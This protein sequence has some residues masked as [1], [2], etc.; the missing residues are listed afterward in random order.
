MFI[1]LFYCTDWLCLIMY[2]ISRN[3]FVT[4]CSNFCE[5]QILIIYCQF[6]SSKLTFHVNHVVKEY[7][8]VYLSNVCSKWRNR[9]YFATSVHIITLVYQPKPSA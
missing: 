5:I 2:F 4:N 9:V 7:F 8:K 1:Y 3:Y 6:M